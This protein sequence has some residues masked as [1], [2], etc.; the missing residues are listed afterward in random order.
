MARSSGIIRSGTW[1][2]D[3]SVDRPVDVIALEFDW[4]YELAR[5][6]GQLEEGEEPAS[7]GPD[8]CLYYARFQHAGTSVSPTTVDSPGFETLDEA[9]SAAQAKVAGP[10][11]WQ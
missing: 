5:A 6:D 3:G 4:W 2:Y 9:M 8:G 10:I 11:K 1:L 7:V